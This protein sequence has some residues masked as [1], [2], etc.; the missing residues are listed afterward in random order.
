MRFAIELFL[1]PVG[2]G[3]IKRLADML[4]AQGGNYETEKVCRPTFRIGTYEDISEQSLVNALEVVGKEI[5]L[6]NVSFSYLGLFSGSKT[7]F[8]GATLSGDLLNAH[9]MIHE[10]SKDSAYNPD[11]RLLPGNWV[12]HCGVATNIGRDDIGKVFS[13]M[14]TTWQPFK[15][16]VLVKLQPEIKELFSCTLKKW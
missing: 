1:D 3:K 5:K 16:L 15:C 7:A 6:L 9:T 8:C 4:R 11:R 12:P 10:K 13:S 14:Y 2:Q